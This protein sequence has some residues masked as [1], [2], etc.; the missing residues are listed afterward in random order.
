MEDIFTDAI[1]IEHNRAFNLHVAGRLVNAFHSD[2]KQNKIPEQHVEVISAGKNRMD[3]EQDHKK[4]VKPL[5]LRSCK[6][7]RKVAMTK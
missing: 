5:R 1:S 4:D 6:A 2:R 7:V 3:N